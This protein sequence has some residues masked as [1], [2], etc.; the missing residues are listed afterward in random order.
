[1]PL[2]AAGMDAKVTAFFADEQGGNVTTRWDES[3]PLREIVK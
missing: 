3:T 2:R 1:V